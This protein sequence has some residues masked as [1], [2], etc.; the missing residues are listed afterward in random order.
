MKLTNDE[1]TFILGAVDGVRCSSTVDA[2]VKGQ[3]LSKLAVEFELRASEREGYVA[4]N[5]EVSDE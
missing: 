2:R 5:P 3:L 4:D 1:L